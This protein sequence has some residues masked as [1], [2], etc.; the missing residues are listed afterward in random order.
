MPSKVAYLVFEHVDGAEFE[1]FL[2]EQLGKT[3]AELGE[4]DHAEYVKWMAYY[5]R[6]AQRQQLAKGG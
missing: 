1:F 3:V 5:G 2:A 6:K 4:M